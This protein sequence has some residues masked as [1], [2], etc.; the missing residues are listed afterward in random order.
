VH[1]FAFRILRL[2][3]VMAEVDQHLKYAFLIDSLKTAP[4]CRNM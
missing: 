4:W 1:I 3:I 2:L